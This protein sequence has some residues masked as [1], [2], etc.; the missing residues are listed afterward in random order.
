MT[1]AK[2]RHYDHN[3]SSVEIASARKDTYCIEASVL[4]S[5]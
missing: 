1:A 2:L 4:G 5:W 3:V